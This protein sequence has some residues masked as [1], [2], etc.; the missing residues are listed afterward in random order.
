MPSAY[1]RKPKQDKKA[2][3]LP[4]NHCISCKHFMWGLI[5][6]YSPADGACI[7]DRAKTKRKY[8]GEPA[9]SHWERK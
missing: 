8:H 6:P 4:A 1:E 2:E 7:R 9:C 5:T 3:P